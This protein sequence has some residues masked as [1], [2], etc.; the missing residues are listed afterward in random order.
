MEISLSIETCRLGEEWGVGLDEL[1][2]QSERPEVCLVWINLTGGGR[3]VCIDLSR[4]RFGSVSGGHAIRRISIRSKAIW[5]SG[6]N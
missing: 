2:G 3:V 4:G 5:G 6:I 1:E